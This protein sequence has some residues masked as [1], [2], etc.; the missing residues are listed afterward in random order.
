[1]GID[2][3]C[4]QRMRVGLQFNQGPEMKEKFFT[5]MEKYFGDGQTE[6]IFAEDLKITLSLAEDNKNDLVLI[7]RMIAKYNI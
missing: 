7:N 1:M 2:A 3:Y 5:R 4:S 6:N